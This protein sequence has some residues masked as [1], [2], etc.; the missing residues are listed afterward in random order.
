MAM[1]I[2]ACVITLGLVCISRGFVEIGKG[3]VCIARA[4]AFHKHHQ[5]EPMR[6]SMTR[7]ARREGWNIDVRK[8]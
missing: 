3:L 1:I 6:V 4:L 5:I 8:V 2:C 7:D